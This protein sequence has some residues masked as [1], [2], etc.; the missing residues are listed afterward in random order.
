MQRKAKD[1]SQEEKQKLRKKLAKATR[2]QQNVR[3]K[4]KKPLIERTKTVNGESGG[5]S[6]PAFNKDGQLVF[7]RFDFSQTG[8][9]TKKLKVKTKGDVGKNYKKMLE[10]VTKQKEKLSKL[11]ETNPDEAESAEMK[12]KWMSALKKA[13]GMKVRDDPEK[14]K[15]AL[16]RKEKKKEK[17]KKAWSER[18]E[19]VEKKQKEKQEKRTQNLAKRKQSNKDKKIKKLQKKGRMLPGF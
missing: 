7:S 9:D 5:P 10:N 16:K 12:G 8:K 13:E 6:R 4:T 3:I 17:S 14:L 11:K 18:K 19:A 2:K 1:L 15:K